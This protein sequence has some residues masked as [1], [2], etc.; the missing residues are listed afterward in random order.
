MDV[1][2]HSGAPM[3]ESPNDTELAPY[4]QKIDALDDQIIALLIERIGIVTSVGALKRQ[5]APG[6]CPVRAG[7]EAEMVRRI[8]GKFEGSPFPPAA[9]A[10][11]WR[12][13]IGASTCIEHPLSLSVYIP[14]GNETLYWLAREYF[15]PTLPAV[16]QPHVKRVLGD[17]MDGKASIGI[18]PMPPAEG[19]WWSSLMPE[20]VG[21]PKIFAC[22]PFIGDGHPTALAIACIRPEPTGDDISFLA[23]DTDG[24]VSQNRLQTAFTQARLQTRWIGV[25]TPSASSIRRHLI[26]VKGFVTAS[27]AAFAPLQAELGASLQNIGFLG[28]YAAP[29]AIKN[30]QPSSFAY[31]IKSAGT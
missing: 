27:D 12:V 22:L 31:A 24:N 30:I 23:F 4:R 10:A 9:A 3:T 19:D 29:V 11:M 21:T 25:V 1:T 7:R 6:R 5:A 14:E 15:G 16:R 26:E 2:I 8:M 20:S 18:V 17:V 28:A 13:L